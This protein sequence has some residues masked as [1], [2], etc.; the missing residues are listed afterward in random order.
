MVRDGPYN[1]QGKRIDFAGSLSPN[2]MLGLRGR[3]R[4]GVIWSIKLVDGKA[5]TIEW[6]SKLSNPNASTF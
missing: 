2:K 3:N 1:K 4:N 5:L 6:S